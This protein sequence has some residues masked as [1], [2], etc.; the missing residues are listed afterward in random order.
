M[1]YEARVPVS[2]ARIPRHVAGAERVDG[3]LNT[4][5][6]AADCRRHRARAVLLGRSAAK[7]STAHCG[8]LPFYPDSAGIDADE[9]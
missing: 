3:A 5:L 7:S 4:A 2:P 9:R 1:G 8:G 6:S